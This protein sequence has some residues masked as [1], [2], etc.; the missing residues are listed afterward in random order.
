MK[1]ELAQPASPTN[2]FHSG[3]KRYV[4]VT[5]KLVQWLRKTWQNHISIGTCSLSIC[6][7]FAWSWWLQKVHKY[8]KGF[9][10]TNIRKFI[11]WLL[12]VLGT[13]TGPHILNY[14]P[15]ST[16]NLVVIPNQFQKSRQHPRRQFLTR[17]L[18][19]KMVLLFICNYI[20]IDLNTST[21]TLFALTILQIYLLFRKSNWP[22]AIS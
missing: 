8:K 12:K 20:S 22:K 3:C 13:R 14:S 9:I 19:D 6:L 15:A 16:Q 18:S 5:Q 7:G 17:S 4:H 10:L 1:I 21:K 2:N 11:F